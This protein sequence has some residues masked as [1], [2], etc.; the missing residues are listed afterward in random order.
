[1]DGWGKLR[2]FVSDSLIQVFTRAVLLFCVH[3]VFFFFSFFFWDTWG[4]AIET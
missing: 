4:G 3:D 2:Y 1:M